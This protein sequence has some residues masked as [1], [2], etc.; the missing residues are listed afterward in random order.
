MLKGMAEKLAREKGLLDDF[1]IC[2]YI[3]RRTP[4]LC[5]EVKGI[6]PLSICANVDLYSGFV[7]NALDIPM[8]VSTPF[9]AMARL[10]G[11]CAHRLEEIISGKKLIRPAYVNVQPHQEYVPIKKRKDTG[12]RRELSRETR[13]IRKEALQEAAAKRGTPL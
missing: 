11:W 10:S 4:S 2:D 1:M 7:Y 9:F 8:D 5:Y 12:S 3:E 13:S 6:N